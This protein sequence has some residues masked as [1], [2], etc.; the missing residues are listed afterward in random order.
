MVIAAE[1]P[2]GLAESL[3]TAIENTLTKCGW[4]RHG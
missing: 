2:G 1:V 3:A 4:I